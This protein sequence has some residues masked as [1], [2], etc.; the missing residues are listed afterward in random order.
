M[1]KQKKNENVGFYLVSVSSRSRLLV[2]S[3]LV[4]IFSHVNV[5]E[6]MKVCKMKNNYN[7]EFTYIV[8]SNMTSLTHFVFLAIVMRNFN[9]LF[10]VLATL[11]D[12]DWLFSILEDS[13]D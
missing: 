5:L 3:L 10:F 13:R 8:H 1:Q 9:R 12:Y 6:K 2:V 7:V 11:F 4:T